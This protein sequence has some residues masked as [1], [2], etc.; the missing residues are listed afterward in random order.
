VPDST[1]V[2]SVGYGTTDDIGNEV[3]VY[4]L[5]AY[6]A[7]AYDSGYKFRTGSRKFRICDDSTNNE[8]NIKSFADENFYAQGYLNTVE[9]VSVSVKV[10]TIQTQS[11]S[12]TRN[13]TNYVVNDTL[14]GSSV[15]ADNTPI[16]TTTGPQF[17]TGLADADNYLIVCYAGA[18]LAYTAIWDVSINDGGQ[19]MGAFASVIG[20][21]VVYIGQNYTGILS[22]EYNTTLASDATVGPYYHRAAV[23]GTENGLTV[24]SLILTPTG[25]SPSSWSTLW[26]TQTVTWEGGYYSGNNPNIGLFYNWNPISWDIGPQ[27]WILGLPGGYDPLTNGAPASYTNVVTI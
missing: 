5:P 24:G 22:S 8:N 4:H 2:Y 11:V 10:P 14:V 9:D 13:M 16:S 20:W 3:G 12:E 17:I 26:K 1:S 15:I 23:P 21:R 7:T 25:I 18:P 6:S 19:P 27:P